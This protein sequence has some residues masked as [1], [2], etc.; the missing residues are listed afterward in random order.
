MAAGWKFDWWQ[1]AGAEAGKPIQHAI[2]VCKPVSQIGDARPSVDGLPD[3]HFGIRQGRVRLS[4]Y[5]EKQ[6]ATRCMEVRPAHGDNV[7]S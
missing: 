2:Q 5:Q 6:R 1:F 3:H 7:I 4:R